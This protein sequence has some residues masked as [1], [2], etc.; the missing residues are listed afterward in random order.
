M[1]ALEYWRAGLCGRCYGEL[2]ETS[3]AEINADNPH[4]TH[5]YQAKPP[6]R[7]HRCTALMASEDEYRKSAHQ[8]GALIHQVEKIPRRRR[9]GG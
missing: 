2:A 1:L 3:A 7:C 5:I 8:P 9:A 6:K 4:G